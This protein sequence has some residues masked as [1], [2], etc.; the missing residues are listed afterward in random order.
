MSQIQIPRGTQDIL[1]GDVELWQY[2]ETKAK[3]V[4]RR[5]N[6]HEIRTPIFEH[7]DLFQRGVG[8]TTDIVQKE[9][10]TFEDRG[11]RSLT[12]R[13]EGTAAVVRSFVEKKLYGNANQPTKLY[14]TGPMFRYERPQSGRMRQFIQ[15]GVEALGSDDPALDA[16]VLALVMS[17]YGELGLKDIKLV[18][19][20]L[21]DKTSRDDHRQALINHFKPSITEFCEDCQGRLEKNPLRILDCK[22]DREHQLMSTAPSILAYL[23]EE[24]KA[25]FDK[26]KNY[27]DKIGIAYEVD[28]TLV[29]GLDYYNHT[30]FEVM[31]VG[32]GFG[33]ITTLCGGGRYNGLVEEIGGPPTAG[34]GFAF[35]IERLIMA[36]KA[37]QLELP[38]EQNIDCYLVSL[39]EQA[40]EKTVELLYRLRAAGIRADKDYLDKKMK[41]Q[42]K[43]ADRLKASYTV[44]LGDDE[45]AVNKINVKHME[46]GEQVEV[47]IDS[48]IDYMKTQLEG[49][50]EL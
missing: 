12:L 1:P 23:N 10:Y 2:I 44:I 46:T 41:A 22:K 28:P 38:F 36:L 29:R 27:L 6:Y 32:K 39:G 35:S 20:S 43:A 15:F 34:I 16:E 17:I 47:A 24:S 40:K 21:G 33:A 49:G 45:L 13:P 3:D 4:C 11:K 5:Y 8:D 7:T 19:N 30:A 25:Y 14:Y 26:V 48:L 18:I 37:H 50:K 9:M 31:A 42:F